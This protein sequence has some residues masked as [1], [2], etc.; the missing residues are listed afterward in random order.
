[1]KILY[2]EIHRA[3]LRKFDEPITAEN[4][5]RYMVLWEDVAKEMH[6]KFLKEGLVETANAIQSILSEYEKIQSILTEY[7]K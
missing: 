1:M 3:A 5:D 2:Q 7:E 6:K 4:H